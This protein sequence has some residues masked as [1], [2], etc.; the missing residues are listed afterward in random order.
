LVIDE[1]KDV[2][3]NSKQLFFNILSYK[4]HRN[5][6]S[7][8]INDSTRLISHL[9]TNH[10]AETGTHYITSSRKEYMTMFYKASGGGIIVGA[11]CTENAVRIHSRKRFF[12]C[13]FIFHELCDGI[14]DDLS[15]GFHLSYETACNDNNDES[16]EEGNIKSSSTEFAHLVSK[17]FRSQFIAFVGNVLLSFP[18]AL[19]IIYGLDVFFSQNLAIERSDKLLKDLDPFKSKAI[20]HACIAGFYLFISG[21]IS[22]ISETIRCSIRFGKNCEKYFH[23]SFIR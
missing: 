3:L 8:L 19:L 17:L 7:E 6:I 13:I 20:L 15:H 22:G 12:S 23:Q 9:I 4:S 2:L 11:L 5:N 14:R 10:T 21:I 18:I 1:E 16:F